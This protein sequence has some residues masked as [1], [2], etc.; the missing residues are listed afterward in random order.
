VPQGSTVLVV[1]RGDDE[2]L[3]LDGRRGL[4]FP[5][6]EPGVFAGH[7]PADSD[8]AIAAL[9]RMRSD[10]CSYFVVPRPGLWWLDH[11]TASP[12]IWRNNA[13]SV[14]RDEACVLYELREVEA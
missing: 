13:V 12:S 7:Y 5:Q 1:S 6:D 11:Y 3:V 10:G 4:H 2:L 8:A 14:V 9:E